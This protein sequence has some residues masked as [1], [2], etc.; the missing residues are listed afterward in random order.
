[1]ATC[2]ARSESITAPQPEHGTCPPLGPTGCSLSITA[3]EPSTGH[4]AGQGIARG[5][6]RTIVRPMGSD[7]AMTDPELADGGPG[8]G[9]STPATQGP[10]AEPADTPPAG[11]ASAAPQ[12]A[13]EK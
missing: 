9:T 6:R 1:M 12:V 2:P 7:R 5:F 11:A 13:A 3:R 4:G 10:P 8:S